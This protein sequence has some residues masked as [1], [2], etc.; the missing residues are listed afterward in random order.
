MTK[1]ANTTLN[2]GAEDARLVGP[3]AELLV[4]NKIGPG[5]SIN[6]PEGAEIETIAAGVGSLAERPRLHDI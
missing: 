2:D 5:H 1:P 3:P 6:G 4:G